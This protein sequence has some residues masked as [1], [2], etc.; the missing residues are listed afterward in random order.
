MQDLLAAVEMLDKFGDATVVFEIRVLG[1]AGLGVVGA[2]VGERDE[3]AFVQEGELAQALG[4]R[5]VVVLGRG[6]DALVR[7][8]ADLGAG[9]HFRGAGLLQLAGGFAFRVRLLPGEAVAPD[10]EFQFLAEGV[11]DGHA[12]TVQPAG[13]F[14]RGGIEFSARM[15]LGHDHLGGGNFFSIDVHVVDGNAAAVVD[16]GDGVVDVNGDFDLVGK[17][18]EGFVHG[19]VDDFIDEMVQ[20][21]LAGRTD[22]H[23]GTFADG[24]HAAEHLDGVG[25]VVAIDSVGSLSVF[26]FRVG[27]RG[28]VQSLFCGHSAP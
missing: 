1:L 15:Q 17:S 3:Q 7:Q 13:N 11:D 21:H 20:S 27:D 10:F 23:G 8:E 2:L 18:G 4:E 12:D 19:V 5:V 25:S 6:E 24:F 9:L 22:V 14:V 26:C 28:G 16:D